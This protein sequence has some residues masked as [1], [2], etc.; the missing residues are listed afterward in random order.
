MQVILAP[1]P[2]DELIGMY[3]L[4]VGKP[5]DIIVVLVEWYNDETLTDRVQESISLSER[6][7]YEVVTTN[8]STIGSDLEELVDRTDIVWIPDLLDKQPHHILIHGI[9]LHFS[10]VYRKR[11]GIYTTKMNTHY[12]R[13]CSNKQEK[14]ELAFEYFTSQRNYFANHE[15]FFIYEGH[16]ILL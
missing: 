12:T 9:G 15:E 6:L 8:I 5:E 1:H 13:L 3:E 11:L 7:G 14:K 16:I 2:D 10:H 4:L